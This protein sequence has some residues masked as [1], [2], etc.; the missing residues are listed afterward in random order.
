MLGGGALQTELAPYIQLDA[1]SRPHLLK[2]KLGECSAA[3]AA[4]NGA[5]FDIRSSHTDGF[6]VV[7]QTTGFVTNL[8]QRQGSRLT[9]DI[10]VVLEDHR[11][12]QRH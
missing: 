4:M 10:W 11:L 12:I 5:L 9:A 3:R 8:H 6:A 2:P 1:L 7:S